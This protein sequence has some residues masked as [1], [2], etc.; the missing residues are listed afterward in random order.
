[1]RNQLIFPIRETSQVGAARRKM[2]DLASGLGF[3]EVEAEKAAII[4]TEMGTNLVKHAGGGAL[5]ARVT[6]DKVNGQGAISG[7]EL[8]ALDKGPGMRNVAECLRDGFSTIGSQ[9]QGLGAINRLA[10]SFEV[11]SQVGAGTVLL[12]N[13]RKQ[14]LPD[15]LPG[16]RFEVG[17]ICLPKHG[18]EVSG[19]AWIAAPH[20]D[21]CLLLVADGLGHGPN[22]AAAADEAVRAFE[23]NLNLPPARLLEAI[24]LALRPTRGA[25]VAVTEIESGRQVKFA[26]IGNIAGSIVASDNSVR[27]MVSHNGIAGHEARKFQEFTYPWPPGALLILHSDGLNTRWRLES[28]PGLTVRHPGLVAGVLYRD[29]DRKTD[30]VTV[31]VARER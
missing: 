20:P 21:R 28:Y 14:P 29:F 18:E 26:G 10:S 23:N 25:S 27:H 31:L 8:L 17:G 24:H 11:Y 19:D 6:N 13:L 5:L 2:A 3:D 12:A 4:V 22:A 30:D 9:G 16:V 1:M 15:K 7:I